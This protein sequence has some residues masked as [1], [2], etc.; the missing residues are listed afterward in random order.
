[1]NNIQVLSRNELVRVILL[2][3]CRFRERSNSGKNARYHEKEGYDRPDN[4]PALRGAP[5]LLS[6]D[7]RIGSIDFSK[8]EIVALKLRSA[9]K[10][11]GVLGPTY[12][13]PNAVKGRHDANEKHHIFQRLRMGNKPT[14]NQQSN[15][16]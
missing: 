14:R 3:G 5:I 9:R 4:T 13:I 16:Q 6:E 12:N 8:D 2:F 10:T 1:V 7:V 11:N 15:R